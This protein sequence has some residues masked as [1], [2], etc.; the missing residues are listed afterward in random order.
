M[1]IIG[2]IPGI[3]VGAEFKDRKALGAAGVHPSQQQGI[4]TNDNIATSIVL[5][6]G[7]D[8]EDLGDVIVYC[9][10]GGRDKSGKLVADQE[11]N[12]ANRGL[13]ESFNAG[14]PIRVTRGAEH[15]S[16]FSPE[17]GYR[18]DG[19]YF[20]ESYRYALVQG[21]KVYLFRLRSIDS[22]PTPTGNP[23]PITLELPPRRLVQTNAIIRNAEIA[24]RVKELYKYRCQICG[25]TIPTSTGFY[26]EAAHI[27]PLGDPHDGPDVISNLLCLCPNH[28]KM[29]DHFGITIDDD[30]NVSDGHGQ[31]KVAASHPLDLN[32][33]KYH[34]E[35]SGR[36]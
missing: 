23:D 36:R 7:Y 2:P 30:L 22:A 1:K 5:G 28:H 8:N 25:T 9:G 15:P 11:L 32:F 31:L 4:H 6:G 3:K 26:A 35:S 27:R 19:C 29:L 16:P 14:N 10:M 17:Q 33:I 34:R 20:I 21:F 13:I 18:Y 12:S 24:Y